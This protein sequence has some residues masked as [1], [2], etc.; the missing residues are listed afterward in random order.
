MS[1]VL[2]EW[3]DS[4]LTVA[5]NRISV[6]NAINTEVLKAL[7]AGL[8]TYGANPDVKALKL[9]GRGGCFA[10]GADIKELAGLDE[11]GIR[12]FHGLRERTFA[13]LENFPAPTLAMIE[14]YALGT[15]LELALCCDFR[16]AA[17]DTKLGVPSAKLGIV[18]SYEYMAR[19]VRAVGPCQAKKIIFTGERVDAQTAL[20]IGLV[21]EITPTAAL[22]QRTA[23]LLSHICANSI[24]AL[25][26]SKKVIAVCTRDPHL[27]QV[28]DT[29]QPMVASIQTADF[30]EGTQAFID[31]RP[32]EFK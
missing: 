9:C 19:L 15:G 25:R 3:K 21:E 32:A 12:S 2:F 5:L 22:F 1:V 7:E 10:A 28:D 18:E 29:A 11:Q 6:R 26:E 16:I 8:R 23:T 27:G 30:K 14:K 17:E 13:L 31:K 24:N 20:A 4:I